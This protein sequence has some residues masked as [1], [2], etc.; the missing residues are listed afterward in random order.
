MQTKF[1]VSMA[2]MVLALAACD[3]DDDNGNGVDN[4]EYEE[5]VERSQGLTAADFAADQVTDDMPVAGSATYQGVAAFD[6][7]EGAAGEINLADDGV[8]EGE[9][10]ALLTDFDATLVSELELEANFDP[11]VATLE[12]EFYNFNDADGGWEG[13]VP[14][15]GAF[16]GAVAAFDGNGVL[17]TDDGVTGTMNI[18]AAG[19]FVGEGTTDATGDG[20]TG[21][22]GGLE[23]GFETDTTTDGFERTYEGVFGVDRVGGIIPAPAP[24]PA[25]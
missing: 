25:P 5:L 15:D 17:T 8:T 6:D 20:A 19:N 14:V 12:G 16:L 18:D 13:N 9:A 23:A 24:A 3:D 10:T 22:V 11:L 2:A 4:P 1:V 21:L 7:L